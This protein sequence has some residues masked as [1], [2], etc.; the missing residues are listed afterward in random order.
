VFIRLFQAL[1]GGFERDLKESNILSQVVLICGSFDDWLD[2]LIDPSGLL[3]VVSHLFAVQFYGRSC[4]KQC[5]TRTWM[6]QIHLQG[7]TL[8]TTGDALTWSPHG[9]KLPKHPNHNCSSSTTTMH[10]SARSSLY[11]QEDMFVVPLYSGIII[12]WA[13]CCYK[14]PVMMT[15]WKKMIIL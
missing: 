5:I 1:P 14:L 11:R 8:S 2:S 9:H 12:T 15:W 4:I 13:P 6:W 10:G 3:L 7:H